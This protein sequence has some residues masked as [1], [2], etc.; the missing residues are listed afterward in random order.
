[1]IHCF[2]FCTFDTRK[3]TP[4][5]EIAKT[6]NCHPTFKHSLHNE[7]HM[8]LNLSALASENVICDLT[9][10]SRRSQRRRRRQA[11]RWWS[12]R[13]RRRRKKEWWRYVYCLSSF[14]VCLPVTCM[15]VCVYVCVSSSICQCIYVGVCMY[16]S[17]HLWL[18]VSTS[19]WLCFYDF[20]LPTV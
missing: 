15:Y 10:Q 20:L 5:D 4:I 18:C 9:C 1:M 8:W 19:V 12:R 13:R 14:S 2:I 7:C 3:V 16:L 17:M 6:V 11:R